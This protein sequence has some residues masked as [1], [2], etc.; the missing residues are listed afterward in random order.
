VR[1]LGKDYAIDHAVLG[2]AALV[3]GALDQE[4]RDRLDACRAPSAAD[5]ADE[6]AA[7]REAWL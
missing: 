4:V 2:D 7:V 6:I 5:P 3:P 1:D